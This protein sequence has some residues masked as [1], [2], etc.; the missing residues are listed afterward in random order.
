[1][2]KQVV[3]TLRMMPVTDAVAIRL[4]ERLD[5]GGVL[6]PDAVMDASA[7]AMLDELSRITPAFMTLRVACGTGRVEDG[8]RRLQPP[9]LT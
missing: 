8:R 9:G 5:R 3:T 2:I 1:M 4:R 6:R 7:A